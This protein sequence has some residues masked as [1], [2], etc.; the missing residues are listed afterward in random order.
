L[1]LWIAA[2]LVFAWIDGDAGLRSWWHLRSDLD[3]ANERIA[4][5]R[6][7]VESRQSA[8]VAL[9]DDE[10]AIERAIRERLEYARPGET[11]VKLRDS[12]HASH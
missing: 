6:G 4:A 8:A 5:L 11:I 1:P 7:D 9:E 3:L 10:F 2:A 12:N